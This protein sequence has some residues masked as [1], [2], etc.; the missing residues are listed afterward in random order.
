[1]LED[2]RAEM[3]GLQARLER[4]EAMARRYEW[5]RLHSYVIDD[6]IGFGPGCDQSAPEYLDSKI[7]DA[8]GYSA[9]LEEYSRRKAA[10]AANE[11]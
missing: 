8:M 10:L 6:Q 7:D 11:K 3:A 5:L 4:A 2:Y 1:M 9:A